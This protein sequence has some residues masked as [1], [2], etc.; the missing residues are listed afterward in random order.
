MDTRLA[1]LLMYLHYSAG[2]QS[3][4]GGGLEIRFHG[5][6]FCRHKII[7]FL[8]FQ[9]AQSLNNVKPFESLANS[10]SIVAQHN[11]RAKLRLCLGQSVQEC[12]G[13]SGVDRLRHNSHI[14]V[15]VLQGF[16]QCI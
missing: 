10:C 11:D 3:S 8:N 2:D 16:G 9:C 5:L 15:L 6:G 13:I 12:V 4:N 1:S 14:R 7:P